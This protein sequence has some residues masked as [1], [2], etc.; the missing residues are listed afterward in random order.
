MRVLVAVLSLLL[1]ACL[2]S[3]GYETEPIPPAVGPEDMTLDATFDLEGFAHVIDYPSSW[4]ANVAGNESGIVAEFISEPGREDTEAS[5]VTPLRVQFEYQSLDF[6]KTFG[7]ADPTLEEL[8]ALNIDFFNVEEPQDRVTVSV[9]GEPAVMI[10]TTDEL[11]A[12]V[13]FVQGIVGDNAYYLL[14]QAP[15]ETTLN[16]F[17]DTWIEML[18]SVRPAD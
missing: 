13:S 8:V 4:V 7:L 9:A 10:R 2:S 17:F 6:M 3:A 15:D 14:L 16:A 1:S 18:A 12:S 11:G 5:G